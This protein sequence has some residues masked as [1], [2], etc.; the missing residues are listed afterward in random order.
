MYNQEIL[1][2]KRYIELAL[3]TLENKRIISKE[4]ELVMEKLVECEM[5]LDRNLRGIYE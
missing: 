3:C 1:D 5:W 2:A 4:V